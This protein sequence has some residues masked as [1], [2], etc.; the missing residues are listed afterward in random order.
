MKHIIKALIYNLG[1]LFSVALL[2]LF[3]L[4]IDLVIKLSNFQSVGTIFIGTLLLL[5][6]LFF[7]IW[8]SIV[9]FEAEIKHLSKKPQAKLITTG[10][11]ALSRN[12]LYLGI[13]FIVSSS[14]LIV[15][16][17]TGIIASIILF[18]I[19]DIHTRYI[20]E[21]RL[22]AVFTKEYIAYKSKVSRWLGKR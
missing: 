19:L 22:E 12:P 10:P 21:Q 4:E 17:I 5:L 15:G 16:S 3:F 14:A 13:I 7:R 9:F 1:L 2:T 8:A 6:G 20:D 18:I 11:F